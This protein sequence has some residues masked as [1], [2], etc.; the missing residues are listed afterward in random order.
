MY[1]LYC[2]SQ[3]TFFRIVFTHGKP[4]WITYDINSTSNIYKDSERIAVYFFL[5]NGQISSSPEG[6]HFSCCSSC[7]PGAAAGQRCLTTLSTS[8]AAGAKKRPK[9]ESS[10]PLSAISW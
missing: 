2:S 10:F 6:F 3:G 8:H 7:L 5:C 4:D 1:T 9:K